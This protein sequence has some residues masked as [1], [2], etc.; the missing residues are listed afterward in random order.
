M[1]YLL[2]RA[3]PTGYT[4]VGK[5]PADHKQFKI[6][7]FVEPAAKRPSGEVVLMHRDTR[8]LMRAAPPA[9]GLLLQPDV[10]PNS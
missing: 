10:V 6:L 3:D 4:P 9:V 5:L 7:R 8:E 2:F 1:K